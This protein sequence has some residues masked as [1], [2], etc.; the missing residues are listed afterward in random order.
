MFF[1]SCG[2]LQGL[3][4]RLVALL[5]PVHDG[6]DGGR[7]F[8]LLGIRLQLH[9]HDAVHLEIVVVAGGVQLGTEVVDEIRVADVR[10]L[11]RRVVGL[12]RLEHILGV[13]HEIQHIGR[14]LAGMGTVQARE[15]LHG[16]DARQPLIDVHPAQQRLIEAGLE[17]VRH[18][19]NLKLVGVERFA[20]V[21]A[22][23][24]G[25]QRVAGFGERR[26]GRIPCP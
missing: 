23:Q 1:C 2:G 15:R 12:E 10:Q 19:Q 11:R 14:V 3:L 18:Q 16:L 26:R 24:V 6:L 22:S 25:V 17:L 7:Q 4:C 5:E 9:G 8:A 21:A 13:V 20:D